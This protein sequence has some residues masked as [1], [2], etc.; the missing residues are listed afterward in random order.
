MAAPRFMPA[1]H[2]S[3]DLDAGP[4]YSRV[5]F[6]SVVHDKA[7]QDN[8]KSDSLP[9]VLGMPNS[10]NVVVSSTGVIHV[11]GYTPTEGERGVPI[12]VRIHFC[13]DLSQPVYVRLL[14]GHKPVATKVRELSGAIYGRWQLDAAAPPYDDENSASKVL[15]S[16]QALNDDNVVVDTVT[17]GEFSY[18][19]PARSPFTNVE[20]KTNAF[21]IEAVSGYGHRPQLRR[22]I[23]SHV[24]SPS[25]ATSDRAPSPKPTQQVRLHR[26]MKTQSLTR[27]KPGAVG[28]LGEELYAQTPI[29]ELVTPLHN[30]CTGWTATEIQSG[31]RLVRF[32]KVQDGRRLIVSCDPISQEEYCEQD[33]VISCIYREES[34][35]CFVTSV[36]V[37]YLLERL[38]NGEFP[39][40]EKNRIRRNLEG[41]RPTTVSK[42]KPG[43]EDFFQR[44]MEFPDPKPRNIEK[45]LKVFK[46]NLLGQALE[47]ILSKYSIYTTSPAEPAD[48]APPDTPMSD[49]SDPIAQRLPYSPPQ[50][51]KQAYRDTNVTT[52][53]HP[54]TDESNIRASEESSSVFDGTSTSSQ[55]TY[56][57]YESDMHVTAASDQE[58]LEAWCTDYK[59]DELAAY[60]NYGTMAYGIVEPLPSSGS[61]SDGS[62]YDFHP[63]EGL[64]FPDLSEQP[65]NGISECYI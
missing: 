46:W 7:S 12:T 6:S 27:T 25:P 33:S 48:T 32:S 45:D 59:V 54:S 57:L 5:P 58:T 34:N 15:L 17:F 28:D 37:I 62:G 3:R 64:S 20:R 61:Y 21:R 19:A 24:L 56:P 8:L 38:T 63:Y 11:L 51:L 52:K 26:R 31:R 42:H 44:I 29:L 30:I 50:S 4:M 9:S 36:D 23:T 49:V 35:T 60:E 10:P 47:K 14:V 18:W 40:E 39:V 2:S 1:S 22:R 53:H 65:L 13:S 43:Y 16:V 55:V 41:L